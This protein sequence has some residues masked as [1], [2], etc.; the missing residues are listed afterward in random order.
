MGILGYDRTSAGVTTDS[1]ARRVYRRNQIADAKLRLDRLAALSSLADDA[2]RRVEPLGIGYVRD[3]EGQTY[4]IGVSSLRGLETTPVQQEARLLGLTT[5]DVARLREDI[6][7]GRDVR[8]LGQPFENRLEDLVLSDARVEPATEA[9]TE[10]EGVP[11]TE[12]GLIDPAAEPQPLIVTRKTGHDLIL[13]RIAE[14][15]AEEEG[16]S[17]L[18]PEEQMLAELEANLERL[19]TWLRGG[20]EEEGPETGEEPVDAGAP[21]TGDEESDLP[22]IYTRPPLEPP[23]IGVILRHGLRV[24]EL[25]SKDQTRFN[26]LVASGE[27]AL[28]QGEYFRAERR[29]NRALRFT[30]GH[31]MATAGLAHAQLGAGLYVAAALTVRGLFTHQPE[32]IDTRYHAALVPDATRLDRAVNTLRTRIAEADHA[33]DALLLAYVGRLLDER[34]IIEEGVS[35]LAAAAPDDPL[36]PLLQTIWLGQ[37]ET[38]APPPEK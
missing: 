30:P 36:L 4:S 29:F 21:E 9:G 22:E 19:R 26:E 6:V 35:A 37:E 16:E 38:G 2:A 31:P 24:D 27:E 11:G 1:L 7:A 15:Y 10:P 28:R 5:F 18:T 14:R 13:E 17:D 25:A 34:P 8:E 32:M 33:S 20:E 12:P 3:E 23:D